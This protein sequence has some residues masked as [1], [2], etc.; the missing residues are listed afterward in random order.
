MHWQK[1]GV[2]ETEMWRYDAAGFEEEAAINEADL[3]SWKSSDLYY[4]KFVL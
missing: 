1:Q 3:Q 4:N 2:T